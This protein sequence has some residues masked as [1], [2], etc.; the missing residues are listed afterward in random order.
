MLTEYEYY[1]D[2]VTNNYEYFRQLYILYTLYKNKLN[3]FKCQNEEKYN[4]YTHGRLKEVKIGKFDENNYNAIQNELNQLC[5]NNDEHNLFQ[6]YIDDN[7]YIIVKCNLCLGSPEGGCCSQAGCT[8]FPLE[9][10]SPTE[11]ETFLKKEFWITNN[12][13]SIGIENRG[14][15]QTYRIHTFLKM[16][17]VF[18][19]LKI[20]D[21]HNNKN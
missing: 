10:Y 17:C 4:Y 16:F 3:L 11:Y 13:D 21:L 9:L 1:L 19:I 5:K 14:V 2:D 8:V 7:Y 18:D 12:Y 20:Y 15:F 6:K